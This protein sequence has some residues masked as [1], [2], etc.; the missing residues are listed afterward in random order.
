MKK[1]GDFGKNPSSTVMRMTEWRAGDDEVTL[2]IGS[3]ADIL[4][5]KVVYLHPNKN[6]STSL[7]PDAITLIFSG[8]L[9]LE[10]SPFTPG[11]LAFHCS[12]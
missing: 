12:N 4:A 1:M 8:T 3:S 2:N 5:I 10:Y 11:G 6:S 9:L 7:C